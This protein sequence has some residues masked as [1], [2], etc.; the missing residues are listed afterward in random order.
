MDRAVSLEARRIDL[1]IELPFQLGH[2]RI[3]PPAHEW[4]IGDSSNRMQPQ[5]MKVLVALHDKMGQVVT[6]EELIDRC[7]DGRV[8]GE[9]VIN[10][11]ISLLRRVAA[12]SGSFQIDTVPRAGYRLAE[13]QP[14]NVH[15]GRSR[16]NGGGLAPWSRRKWIVATSATALL[17]IAGAA[18]LF[19]F[20]RSD[21][22][23][24]EAVM[25]RPFDVAGNAPLARTF[26]AGVSDDVKNALAVAG[27]DVIDTDASHGPSKAAF[28]L[29][30]RAELPGSDLH[31]TAQLE[32]ARD[33]TVL[34][35]TAF[36]RPAAQVQA[37]QEQVAANLARVLHCALD[38]W[39]QPDGKQ[40]D[41][42]TIK[43]YLKACALEQAVD[44][45]SDEIQ[46]LLQQVTARQPRFAEGWARLAFFSANAAFA[47]SPRDRIALRREARAAAQSALRLNPRS[48]LAHEALTELDLG[49][50][51][52]AQIYREAQFNLRLDPNTDYVAGDGGELL[53]RMGRVSEG[54]ERSRRGVG[55]DP[56]S[57]IQ[58][59]DLIIALI[60][61]SRMAEASSTL[62]RA[63]RIW[64]DDN[65]LRVAHLDYEARFG[66]PDRALAILQ[67]PD[68]RP[69]K[70]R[71]VTL[72]AYRRLAET[73]KSGQPAARRAY[74]G[75]LRAK[76][77]SGQLGV[78]FAAPHMAEFG[79]VDGA[80]KL[81]FAAPPDVINIDP[82]FLWEPESLALRRDPRF[83]ALAAK[84]HVADFWRETK[85]WP[86]FCSTEGWP[87]DCK[88]EDARLV[89]KNIA[90][91]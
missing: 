20:E 45:P 73:R 72:E 43:L 32:D 75:W 9:D 58:T 13:T 76:T 6:R 16:A 91:G 89:S 18:G 78:D 51:P 53:L 29:S 2:A 26:A 54:L 15:G 82:E 61:N 42:G 11:C 7:W 50:V 33:H 39:R 19:G 31:L 80:F 77:V 70:V 86:D 67:D 23:A 5:T 85:L 44:P 59:S 35:S 88:A 74:V 30:G 71:D 17:L 66:N 36:T 52:F 38:T 37:M 90:K 41:Q 22:P 28:V 1:T 27:V 79:D 87:Y 25:L 55:L 69:Q 10:R 14:A 21:G 47:A 68:E 48:A 84:F 4:A 34:W 3:D 46:D 83:I 60:D 63:L 12:E 65:N 64:P 57:P 24:S 40:L 81:A 8:V 62:Q 56:F 49:R